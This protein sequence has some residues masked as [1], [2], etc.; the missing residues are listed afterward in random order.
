M[1]ASCLLQEAQ[2][3]HMRFQN[4]P[5]VRLKMQPNAPSRLVRIGLAEARGGSPRTIPTASLPRL[6]RSTALLFSIACGLAVANVYYAQPLL[7]TMARDFGISHAAIG[8]VITVT[9]IGYGAGL[10][11]I[12][13]LGD[14]ISRRRLVCELID[15]VRACPYRGGIG[16][17]RHCPADRNRSRRRT[18]GGDASPCRV[19]LDTVPPCRT[20]QGGCDRDKRYHCGNSGRASS[21][22]HAF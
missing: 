16:P 13:P 12:V 5:I 21:V 15:I 11:L 3:P 14:I 18:R 8:V 22:R 19:R 9:Q 4:K 2:A 17:N 1:S 10:L 7:D 20:R 6:S